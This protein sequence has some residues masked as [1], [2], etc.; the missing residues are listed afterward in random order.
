MPRP[1][2]SNRIGSAA[3]VTAIHLMIGYAF[4]HG[5]QFDFA[6]S[7]EEALTVVSLAADPPP[8]EPEPEPE[9]VS[10]PEPRP[11]PA[12]A[13]VPEPDGAASPPNLRAQASP[14][15]APPPPIVLDVPPPVVV[16]PDPGPGADASAGAAAVAGPGTGA[17]GVGQGTGA[18]RG[19]EG[20]GG[21]GGGAPPVR[22][23]HLKGRLTGSDYPRAAGD[24]GVQG[25]V[26]AFFDV[27]TDGRVSGCRV[28]ESSRDAELDMVTCRLIER[29]FRYA[30][31]RDAAGRPV[32]D[33]MG[34][35][36]VWWIGGRPRNAPPPDVV[37]D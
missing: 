19:G 12:P 27:G 31:A 13:R 34:W 9:P 24:A 1:D 10:K 33:V 16:A 7:A 2:T 22:A 23:R 11:E 18:G 14:I 28:V 17:G 36:E 3:A 6:R 8:P 21:G 15:V 25:T 5:L 30:P 32:R 37:M 4:V 26:L 20:S 29:R 35:K